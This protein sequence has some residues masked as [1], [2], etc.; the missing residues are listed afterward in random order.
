M[1]KFLSRFF[2]FAVPLLAC[3]IFLFLFP[4]DRKYAYD[5]ISKGGCQGRPP[6]IYQRVFEDTTRIDVAFIGTSHTLNSVNDALI[7]KTIF[8][9]TGKNISCRN[10]A[11]CGFGRDFDYVVIKDLLKHKKVKAIV[12]EIREGEAQ[13]GHTSFPFVASASDLF[14]APKYFNRSYLPAIYKAFF[15]RVQYVRE[16]FTHEDIK[17]KTEI[18][19]SVFGFNGIDATIDG[20]ELDNLV[21]KSQTKEQ[22]KIAVI[23]QELN[24]Y[25]LFY[26]NEIAALSKANHTALIFLYLPSYVSTIAQKE[27]VSKYSGIGTI[28]LPEPEML[29]D[30][31]NWADAE[32]LNRRGSEIVSKRI[33]STLGSI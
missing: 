15:F 26:V 29:R 24:T 4:V 9:S 14:C 20:N 18:S 19:T 2:L 17:H 28:I 12:L 25:P 13:L 8:D 32:H 1:E 27:I 31:T 5:F 10:L 22:Q 3:A 23:E 30:K 21:V 33:A 6:W 16:L 11:F 7:E